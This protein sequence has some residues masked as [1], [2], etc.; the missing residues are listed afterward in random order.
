[1]DVPADKYPDLKRLWAAGLSALE[2]GQELG[3]AGEPSE[4]REAVLRAV[5]LAS[6][7]APKPPRVA[8]P[9]RARPNFNIRSNLPARLRTKA[10]E[11]VDPMFE[12]DG[13]D[14]KPAPA[15]LEIP[16]EQRRSLLGPPFSQYPEIQPSECKWPVGM[17]KEAAFFYCGAAIVPNEAYCQH[18]CRRAYNG[19]LSRCRAA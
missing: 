1:M 6:R 8:K 18:H 14:G 10:R 11:D 16:L 15:D 13:I 7:P 12:S 4:V 3:L 5:E 2:V 9:T 19:R 17:P